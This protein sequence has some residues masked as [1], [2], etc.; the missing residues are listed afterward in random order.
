MKLP[1][2]LSIHQAESA[3]SFVVQGVLFRAVFAV[4]WGLRI[5]TILRD[6]VSNVGHLLNGKPCNG[7]KQTRE[8]KVKEDQVIIKFWFI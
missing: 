7:C 6:D 1:I 4:L 3:I 2:D 5:K 8:Y